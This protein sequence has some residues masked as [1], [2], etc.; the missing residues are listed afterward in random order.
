MSIIENEILTGTTTISYKW[1]SY[2]S[3]QLLGHNH[4]TM[5][6][7]ENIVN[8]DTVASTQTTKVVPTY[9]QLKKTKMLCEMH[10]TVPKLLPSHSIE[11]GI[12]RLKINKNNDLFIHFLNV[13]T[14]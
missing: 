3:L 14:L 10:G 9:S 12:G 7:S 4:Q 6:H 13:K 5:N 1:K 2:A 8:P 11:Y